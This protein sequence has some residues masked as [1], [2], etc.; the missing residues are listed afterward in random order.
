MKMGFGAFQRRHVALKMLIGWSILGFL[1][2]QN[3]NR[4][5]AESSSGDGLKQAQT[6]SWIRLD[7]GRVSFVRMHPE[8]AQKNVYLT[9][10]LYENTVTK[11]RSWRVDGKDISPE[12]ARSLED[13]LRTVEGI[14]R[15][16]DG[17]Y[18]C[19]GHEKMPQY[20]LDFKHQG[21]EYRVVSVSNCLHGAPFNLLVDG[22]FRIDIEGNIGIKLEKAL[23]DSGLKL[24]IGGNAG[25]MM[26]NRPSPLKGFEG[27]AGQS[28]RD[29]MDG[30]FRNDAV[31]ARRLAQLDGVFGEAPF[32][33]IACNQARSATC[34]DWIARY[35]Y[36]M[37][38]QNK[39]VPTSLL[40]DFKFDWGEN[41]ASFQGAQ[42]SQQ[43]LDALK[44]FLDTSLFQ[45]YLLSQTQNVVVAYKAEA[46]CSLISG[47]APYIDGANGAVCSGWQFYGGSR[48]ASI[49]YNGLEAFW[50]PMTEASQ[51]WWKVLCKGHTLSA[52]MRRMVCSTE[53]MTGLTHA[54]LRG[55]GSSF[56]FQTK[57]GKTKFVE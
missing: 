40:Y 17:I 9:W 51:E 2:C 43:D 42:A 10:D 16:S 36:V 1:S 27:E 45:S 55:D 48:P 37:K 3:A 33:E 25:M 18:D 19:R 26:F 56:V 53:K 32:L 8:A 38:S 5:E 44:R 7:E 22:K 29:A 54:F 31:I 6:E 14:E 39:D 35:T 52:K 30:I 57:D 46:N 34:S 47:L 49:F 20:R 13:L 50:I 41:K 23:A 21:H 11:R 28:P 12:A 24:A 15:E 4:S